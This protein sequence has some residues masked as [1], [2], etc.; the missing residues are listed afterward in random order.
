MISHLQRLSL[1]HANWCCGKVY[2][3]LTTVIL[4]DR[5]PGGS[6]LEMSGG[7]PAQRCTC[8]L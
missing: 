5:D 7:T 4:F 8:G 2:D 3:F 1:A 6:G